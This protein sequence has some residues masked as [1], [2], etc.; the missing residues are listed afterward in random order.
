MDCYFILRKVVILKRKIVIRRAQILEC[1]RKM[2]LQ[3]ACQS[4]DSRYRFSKGSSSKQCRLNNFKCLTTWLREFQKYYFLDVSEKFNFLRVFFLQF[5]FLSKWWFV[6]DCNKTILKQEQKIHQV[7][8]KIDKMMPIIA[9]NFRLR[10]AK[11][12]KIYIFAFIT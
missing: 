6:F 12:I 5:F 2:P 11:W 1:W 7:L 4:R 10:R 3:D 9:K 8:I